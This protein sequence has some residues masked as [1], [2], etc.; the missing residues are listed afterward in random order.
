MSSDF[1]QSV[2]R[3]IEKTNYIIENAGIEKE[4]Y[5]NLKNKINDELIP[6]LRAAKNWKKK[7]KNSLNR[8]Y[9]SE[10][11]KKKSDNLQSYSDKIDTIINMLNRVVIPQIS[12]NINSSDIQIEN[13]KSD[14]NKY[15]NMLD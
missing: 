14:L 12:A 3:E 13:A 9:D 6:K 5:Q 11:A 10:E 15:N 8:C 1:N 4:R 7:K 2:R